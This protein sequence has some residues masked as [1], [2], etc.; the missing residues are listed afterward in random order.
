M[1]TMLMFLA[2][3]AGLFTTAKGQ[4]FHLGKC[5]SPPVQENFDVKKYLGR[6]YEIEKI[7]ASFEKG[8]CIQANY[9]LMENGNI[10]VLNKELSDATGTLLDPGHR[11]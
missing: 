3:L 6:W 8:N 7:P 9:S 10:E 2:T 5:P 11:L 1:V 4:N